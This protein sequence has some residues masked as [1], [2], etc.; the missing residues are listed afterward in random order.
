MNLALIGYGKMGRMIEQLAVARGHRVIFKVDIAGNEEGQ[1]LTKENLRGVEVVL[2]FTVPEAVVRNVDQVT[3]LGVSMVVGIIP[4]GLPV[5]LTNFG[6]I[7]AVR[8]QRA[9]LYLRSGP[10]GPGP[11][12][13]GFT[14]MSGSE[15]AR[16]VEFIPG[17]AVSP[18]S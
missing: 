7:T 1:L 15:L 5:A 12:A 9:V 17:Y 14:V 16:E 4:E 13:Y 11:A 6:Q 8:A 10:A 2:D 3:R 18:R